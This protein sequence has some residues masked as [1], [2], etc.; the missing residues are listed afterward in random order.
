MMQ[1]EPL[2]NVYTKMVR[3]RSTN[4]HYVYVTYLRRV[5][6]LFEACGCKVLLDQ[7]PPF[8]PPRHV[9]W[10]YREKNVALQT[11]PVTYKSIAVVY[12]MP[13]LPPE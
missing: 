4:R 1:Y 2:P 3:S 13:K 8:V 12:A 9:P 7:V 6:D 10:E 11:I 5:T